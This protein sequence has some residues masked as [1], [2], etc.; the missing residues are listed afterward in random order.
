MAVVEN[1][2]N[3][4]PNRGRGDHPPLPNMSEKLF[5]GWWI[6]VAAA[7]GLF[8]SF[9]PIVTYTFGV[10][11]IQLSGEFEWTRGQISLAYSLA[12]LAF[13]VAQPF[14]GR[15]LDR[16]GA[17]RVIVPAVLIFGSI[18]ASLSLLTS[19][20]AHFYGVFLL[21]GAVGGGTT[22]IAYFG[23]LSQWFVKRRG[24]AL[25]LALAGNGLSAFVMPTLSQFLVDSFGWR[26][27]YLV[28]G[29]MSV[30]VSIPIVVL[31]LR[32]TP[33]AMGL[34]PDGRVT[35]DSQ[36][37]RPA[38]ESVSPMSGREAIRT[39]TFWLIV[40]SFLLMSTALVGCMTHLVPML[41]D[42]GLTAQTAAFAASVLGGATLVGRITAGYLLDRFFAPRVTLTFFAL[43][44]FG[45]LLLWSE[46]PG[47]L[48][49]LGAFVI[50]FAASAD[51]TLPYLVAK[52]FGL[53]AFGE[54]FGL[55][56]ACNI[57][58]WVA[59][60]VILGFAFDWMGSYRTMLGMLMVVLLV[61]VGLMAILAARRPPELS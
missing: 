46:A 50:G 20:L 11:L 39:S 61:A 43:G 3:K 17:R 40:I 41:A 19:K 57:L 60:P 52:F 18:F 31:L 27:A 36:P 34:E 10:F 32:E 25:G 30:V 48:A 35:T 5:Y 51:T 55:A 29:L 44:L 22:S 47:A 54:I 12:M 45:I 2:E 16:F 28:L 24:I 56:V 14:V 13:A 1:K 58:G 7:V 42:R 53:K 21:I 37:K 8:M 26:Q 59:G 49:F 9:N 4:E 23:V 33:E 6:V 15:I 38:E